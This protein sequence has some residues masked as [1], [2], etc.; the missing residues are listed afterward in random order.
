MT[1][2]SAPFTAIIG[3][4]D[5]RTSEFRQRRAVEIVRE[6]ATQWIEEDGTR[7]RKKDRRKVGD[8]PGMWSDYLTFPGH[9]DYSEEWIAE[10]RVD[11]EYQGFWSVA[12]RIA[13]QGAVADMAPLIRNLAAM[14]DEKEA[15][16]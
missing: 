9:P 12:R 4:Y 15:R 13:D 1:E 8:K 3:N 11:Q 6:T 5:I 2:T 10:Y 16:A 14:L 7:W